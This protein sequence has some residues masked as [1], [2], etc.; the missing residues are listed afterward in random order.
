M[1][2]Q[3]EIHYRSVAE[4]TPYARN[5]RTHSHEQVV[6][7]AASIMEFGFTNPVLIAEDGEII[8]GHGRVLAAQLLG[9]TEVPVIVLGHLTPAQR[10]AYVLADNKLALNAGWDE[11]LLRSE[12]AALGEESFDLGVL[13]FSDD[14]L[15]ALLGEQAVRKGRIGDDE[16]PPTPPATSQLGDLWRLGRHVLLVG[17]C[18]THW[19]YDALLGTEQVDLV[20]TD[21]PYNVNVRGAAGAILNDHLADETF[22]QFLAAFY[23]CTVAV[24]RPGACIYVAHADSGRTNFTSAFQAS[25]LKLSQVRIW[26]K[27][28]ATFGWQDFNWR[29]EPIL[30]GWKEGAAH[31][32]AGDFT[33]TSVID[34]GELDPNKMTKG[35][36]RELV[37]EIQ[38]K[39]LSTV[40]RYDK[41]SRSELHPTMKPVALIEEMVEASSRE[42][43]LVL[44]PFGGSGST[45][46]ACEKLNRR[47][48]LLELDPHYA[49]VIISRWQAFT[50]RQAVHAELGSSFEQVSLE[51]AETI[52]AVGGKS[53]QHDAT[54]PGTHGLNALK[55]PARPPVGGKSAKEHAP[56]HE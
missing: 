42:N 56:S 33:L 5:A 24:M 12:L 46:I 20:W 1:T 4:L 47:C 34:W 13:G 2:D 55:D 43:D 7:I 32:F 6:Q 21:P 18:T 35:Q 49:D 28:A 31:Y 38:A 9:R 51:R 3:L 45:L 22:R 11:E 44:D 40:V 52:P 10:R 50:E 16:L 25:G 29:H 17:D 54:S 27:Q 26:V 37:K 48:A 19:S 36:L 15:G 39:A 30:Y 23:R 14:E 41:P 8:A 53:A